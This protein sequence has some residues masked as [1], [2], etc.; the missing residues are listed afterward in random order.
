MSHDA[1]DLALPGDSY[2]VIEDQLLAGP[3][4]GD[5][6]PG[7][8]EE[9]LCA[10]LGLGVGCF[11]DLTEDGELNPYS[12]LLPRLAQ[13]SGLEV[14]HQRFP[15][16]DLTAPSD[17]RMREILPVIHAVIAGGETVY[18][19]CW[20]GVGRTGAVVG[21]YLVETGVVPPGDAISHIAELRRHTERA[22]RASPETAAQCALIERWPVTRG[23][24][25]PG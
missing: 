23:G 16:P 9:K 17:E 1:K 12:D 21:C 8:A 4:P 22:H 14:A 10:F 5:L 25:Q 2:W 7:R 20:G 15:V 11:I 6:D 19:H 13:K 24:N 18:V 3:Y